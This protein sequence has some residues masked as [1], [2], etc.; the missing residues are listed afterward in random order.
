MTTKFLTAEES[1]S[2]EVFS[3]NHGSNNNIYIN[4][5]SWDSVPSLSNPAK[6]KLGDEIPIIIPNILDN[7][8]SRRLYIIKQLCYEYIRYRRA[9]CSQDQSLRIA[10]KLVCENCDVTTQ[11]LTGH[12]KSLGLVDSNS[13]SSCL[14]DLY[15]KFIESLPKEQQSLIA[16]CHDFAEVLS[17]V[18]EIKRTPPIKPSDIS[19]QDVYQDQPDKRNS[20]LSVDDDTGDWLSWYHNDEASVEEPARYSQTSDMKTRIEGNNQYFCDDAV[21][22]TRDITT[23][24][25]EYS[26]VMR[27]IAT[28]VQ[29]VMSFHKKQKPGPVIGGSG[30]DNSAIRGSIGFPKALNP[31]CEYFADLEVQY[32]EK[33]SSSVNIITHPWGEISNEKDPGLSGSIKDISKPGIHTLIGHT[34]SAITRSNY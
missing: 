13:L 1:A 24:D 21:I 33:G 34:I 32:W 6:S 15:G 10:R 9:G 8:A 5:P 3:V 7:G 26:R 11:T 31:K 30:D 16:V 22:H 20:V 17:V 4:A 23:Y 25:T 27:K 18:A 2:S 12:I 14:N 28:A 19:Y 29:K